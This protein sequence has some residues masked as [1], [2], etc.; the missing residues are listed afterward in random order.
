MRYAIDQ[1]GLE[2]RGAVTGD[3]AWE[4]CCRLLSQPDN[5]R[6]LGTST[7]AQLIVYWLGPDTDGSIQLPAEMR[8]AIYKGMQ[9]DLIGRGKRVETASDEQAM[10]SRWVKQLI[11]RELDQV[12]EAWLGSAVDMP[13]DLDVDFEMQEPEHA[14]MVAESEKEAAKLLAKV[15]GDGTHDSM[16]LENYGADSEEDYWASWD[17]DYWN[18]SYWGDCWSE[19]EE[20]W[21]DACEEWSDQRA[22]EQHAQAPSSP[23][24]PRAELGTASADKPLV[25]PPEFGDRIRDTDREPYWIPGAYPTI[26]QNESGDP[27][28]Y[29]LKEVDL[30]QW[31]PH[32]LR[33]RGWHAQAHMTF[34]YWWMNMI[35]RFNAL[36][37]KKWYVRDNPK[38]TGYTTEDLSN[39]SV[40]GLAKQMV[41]Y[42]ANIPGTKARKAR[43]RRLVLAMVRQIEIE[44]R[45]G[46]TTSSSPGSTL[47]LGD[48]PCLFGTLTSQRYHWDEVIRIIA[49]VEGIVDYKCLSRSKRR[50]LVNKYPLFVAW[51][52]SV[53]LELTLKAIVVPI[54][55][56]SAYIAVFEWSPTG[57]MVHLHYVL[58]KPGAPRFDLRA[59]RLQE[60][61]Q[62][63][64]KAGLNAAGVV[65]CRIDDVI[66]FFAKYISEWNPNK[67]PEGKEAWGPR[68]RA[69]Q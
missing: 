23:K 37:A 46:D 29:M 61:A 68:R 41:G 59:Q 57:G 20:E 14:S 69:C 40:K 4:L 32:I 8:Q 51:Y 6:S 55:G 31:G 52:C 53:R 27:Y 18:D 1:Q 24:K 17:D 26:F 64:R 36:S 39:M 35:Q 3:T 10:Q 45:R 54:F 47:S 21:Y 22:V 9:E 5:A 28:N 65:R 16:P 33:S 48:V 43:L 63:L 67:S 49:Q 11:H 12:R 7:L 60:R 44:T 42:T 13:V 2:L 19:P 25:D 66:D 38:A 15:A 56:A 30:V 58:W 50:E 34:M 62:E